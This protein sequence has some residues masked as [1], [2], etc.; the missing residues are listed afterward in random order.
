M[1]VRCQAMRRALRGGAT[2]QGQYLAAPVD[3]GRNGCVSRSSLT[4][5]PTAAHFTIRTF[6]AAQGC[7][8][9][10][11]GRRCHMLSHGGTLGPTTRRTARRVRPS[12]SGFGS[13]PVREAD[14]TFARR[15]LVRQHV[16]R[17]GRRGGGK[18]SVRMAR[19]G[20]RPV[21]LTRSPCFVRQ[22]TDASAAPRRAPCGR[23]ARLLSSPR[24]RVSGY[25]R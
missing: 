21:R 23:D 19:S 14:G 25:A 13:L 11:R 4:A 9:S 17:P 20:D 18:A 16:R 8:R 7:A 2:G 12:C 5:E 22:R 6:D 15:Q 24:E 10:V 3:T 1:Y